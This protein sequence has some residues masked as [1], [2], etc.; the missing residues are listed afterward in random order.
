MC[1]WNQYLSNP[2]LTLSISGFSL[3]PHHPQSPL[4]HPPLSPPPSTLAES[5]LTS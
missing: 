4:P 5:L 2:E 3:H 1:A